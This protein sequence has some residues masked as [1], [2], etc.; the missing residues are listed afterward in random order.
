M[1]YIFAATGCASMKPSN[2]VVVLVIAGNEHEGA[3]GED[4][5]FRL[6]VSIHVMG[7]FAHQPPFSLKLVR[8]TYL[9]EYTKTTYEASL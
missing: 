2:N 6:A 1:L 5:R 9:L 8:S 7:L 3:D 4:D